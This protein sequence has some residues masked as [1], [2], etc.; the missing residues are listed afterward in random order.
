MV[1]K[2][3][4]NDEIR[5]CTVVGVKTFKSS[6]RCGLFSQH[7]W[8]LKTEEYPIDTLLQYEQKECCLGK[9]KVTTES[10]AITVKYNRKQFR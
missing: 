8:A 3:Y 2:R 7:S 4:T 6:Y 1:D 10:Q 5:E 9:A